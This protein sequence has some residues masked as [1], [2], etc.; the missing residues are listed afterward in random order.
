MAEEMTTTRQ[1]TTAPGR[2]DALPDFT[3][4]TPDGSPIRA[5]DFHMRRNVALVFTHG[6]DCETCQGLLRE[7][8]RQ[9]KAA[10]AEAGEIVAVIPGSRDDVS[11][12]CDALGISYPVA[13]DQDGSIHRRYGLAV[14]DGSP[15]AGIFV[16][17]RYG[18]IFESSVAVASGEHPALDAGEIPGWLEFI[19]CRCT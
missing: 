7:L 9:R 14:A 10:Q 18:T 5:R 2:G 6:P 13:V 4:V 19:A 17:D 16:A 11:R 1:A 3:T 12:L 15:L 8:A